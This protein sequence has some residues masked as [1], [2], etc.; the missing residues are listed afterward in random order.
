M[1]YT[2]YKNLI[3]PAANTSWAT[4]TDGQVRSGQVREFNVHVQSKLLLGTPVTGTGT[5]LHRLLCPG[6]EKTGVDMK[7]EP[8]AL[9]GARDHQQS[10]PGR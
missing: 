9:A 4:L 7:R 3:T 2:D 1:N 8:L 5:G 10:D 6:Q